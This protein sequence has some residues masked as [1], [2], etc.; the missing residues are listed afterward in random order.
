MTTFLFQDAGK[1]SPEGKKI[2]TRGRGMS[3]K[4]PVRMQ[5]LVGGKT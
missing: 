5:V 1:L 2:P 3:K 4:D